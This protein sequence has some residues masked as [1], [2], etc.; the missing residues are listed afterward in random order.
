MPVAVNGIGEPDGAISMHDHVIDRVEGPA[1]EVT[2]EQFR[3]VRGSDGHA[4]QSTRLGHGPLPADEDAIFVVVNAAVAHR[5]VSRDLLVGDGAGIQVNAGDVDSLMGF[6]AIW[7][8]ASVAG[9]PEV[10]CLRDVD[11]GFVCKGVVAV[12]CE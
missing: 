2:L 3:C 1:E 4:I 11:S 12:F 5:D 10:V 9:D 6:A 8:D 7:I